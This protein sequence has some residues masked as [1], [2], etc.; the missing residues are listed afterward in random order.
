MCVCRESEGPSELI[1]SAGDKGGQLQRRDPGEIHTRGEGERGVKEHS[2]VRLFRSGIPA[3]SSV[4][5]GDC[6]LLESCVGC[7]C[8]YFDQACE[9]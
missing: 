3:L 2:D 4:D 6:S 1:G 8:S 9:S 5:D 7:N